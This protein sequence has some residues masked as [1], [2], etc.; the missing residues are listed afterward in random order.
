MAAMRPARR[1]PYL[2][3]ALLLWGVGVPV[4]AITCVPSA[5]CAELMGTCPLASAVERAGQPSVA[6][7]D[8]CEREAR[9]SEPPG[10]PG[11]KLQPLDASAF[12]AAVT[13]V[14]QGPPVSWHGTPPEPR[15]ET[16]PLY[17][18]HSIL[19]I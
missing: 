7:P 8:C 16:V 15:A 1:L 14:P 19:L 9:D 5:P 18:L 11:A 6:S 4:V 12:S 17:T 2:L 13:L 3:L 10:I